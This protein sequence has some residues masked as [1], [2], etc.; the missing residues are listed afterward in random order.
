MLTQAQILARLYFEKANY[1]DA[2]FAKLAK[3]VIDGPL[4]KLPNTKVHTIKVATAD[5]MQNSTSASSSSSN[6]RGRKQQ[7]L[8]CVYFDVVWNEEHAKEVLEC[9]VKEHGD[10]PNSVKADLYTS[11]GLDSH[12]SARY[13]WQMAYL[14]DLTFFFFF[15]IHL[16]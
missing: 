16:N 15:S 11:I 5:V 6:N 9:L 13:H 10:I 12:V 8:I 3:S 7:W 1:V 4:S 2:V 14:F